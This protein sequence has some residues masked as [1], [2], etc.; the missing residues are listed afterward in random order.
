ME[1]YRPT[2]PYSP[3][4]RHGQFI[5]RLPLIP[6][7]ALLLTGC[8]GQTVV[9]KQVDEFQTSVRAGAEATLV[10][11]KEVN[12]Q[13][14]RLYYM[15]LSLYPACEAGSQLDTSCGAFGS[16]PGDSPLKIAQIPEDSLN[17][18]ISLLNSLAS[19]AKA[20]G[21]LASDSSPEDFAKGIQE[22]QTNFGGLNSQFGKLSGRNAAVD[23]NIDTRYTTPIS[24]IVK[25]LGSEYLAA[26][27]WTA[28]RAAI[29]EARPQVDILL[30]SLESDLT[31]ANYI[32][33]INERR[34]RSNLISYYNANRAKLS[35]DQRKSLLS[36]IE[37]ARMNYEAFSANDPAEVI[38]LM[39]EAHAKLANLAA[40]G[41]TPKSIGEL[42]AILS[43][44]VDRILA[45]RNA[46]AIITSNPSRSAP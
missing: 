24:T 13:N 32:V 11:F 6:G 4:K 30:A 29:L 1:F 46:V 43:L 2:A 37:K 14:R 34:A 31:V 36:D 39:R 45:F 28:V 3:K 17:A 27:K 15:L 12:T 9:L 10:Y 22:V 19:Y 18:R 5:R 41:G 16:E 33:P 21:D 26:R 7:L 23:T 20:L 38:K 25:I 40:D 44:Y 42:R 8:F 35:L